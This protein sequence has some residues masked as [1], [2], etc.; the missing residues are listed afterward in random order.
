MKH[1]K[2]QLITFNQNNVEDTIIEEG[3]NDAD[4][5]TTD[6]QDHIHEIVIIVTAVTLKIERK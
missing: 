2:K 5:T 3:K 1:K 4:M 6:V